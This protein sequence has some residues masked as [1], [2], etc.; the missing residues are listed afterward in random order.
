MTM[1]ERVARAQWE[2]RR[3][4]SA[5]HYDMPVPLEEWGDG[6]L[7]IANGIMKEARAAVEAMREP[8]EAMLKATQDHPD[9]Y[10][11]GDAGMTPAQWASAI[12]AILKE[13]A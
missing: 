10:I 7:P 12:D 11:A 9:H 8:T 2:A 3:K 5:E 13:K 6:A 4:W 1:I